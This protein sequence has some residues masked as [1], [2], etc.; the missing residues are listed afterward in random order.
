M[1]NRE[2]AP[3]SATE[4]I[5]FSALL[6]EWRFVFRFRAEQG[7]DLATGDLNWMSPRYD[8][9]PAVPYI[10]DVVGVV[11]HGNAFYATGRI[12]TNGSPVST[13]RVNLT[14]LDAQ[15]QHLWTRY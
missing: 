10:D 9:I 8:H 11:R 4:M 12:F 6:R 1:Y 14:K 13:C 5:M 3:Y 15:G 7:I 2:V